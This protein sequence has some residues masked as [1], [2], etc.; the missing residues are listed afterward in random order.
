MLALA[1]AST[2]ERRALVHRA[3]VVARRALPRLRAR[4]ARVAAS[5]SATR[6][7]LR[8][9]RV[10]P[11]VLRVD[12]RLVATIGAAHVDALDM[13][14][15]HD[16]VPLTSMTTKQ[17]SALARAKGVAPQQSRAAFLNAL[18]DALTRD[19]DEGLGDDARG[20]AREGETTI[21]RARVARR[22]TEVTIGRGGATTTTTTTRAGR[23]NEFGEEEDAVDGAN[24]FDGDDD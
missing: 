5:S 8:A 2:D 21:E 7:R 15:E 3:R 17:L 1:L 6:R 13:A 12:D 14:L 20:I 23:V 22:T 18:A 24:A 16:G 9:R 11:W 10:W 4:V 19:D